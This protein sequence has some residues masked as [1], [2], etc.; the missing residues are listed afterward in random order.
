MTRTLLAILAAAVAAIVAFNV[1]TR[2]YGNVARR[3]IERESEKPIYSG[4]QEGHD[5]VF[6]QE[7]IMTAEEFAEAIDELI[8][9]ARE[10]GLSDAEMIVVLEDTVEGLDEGLSAA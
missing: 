4:Q 1:L 3:Q 6:T 10:G 8:T 7:V 5:D 2:E 9:A